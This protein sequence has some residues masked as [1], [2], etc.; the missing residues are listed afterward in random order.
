V[1]LVG[2]T[3]V[4]GQEM[5]R[6]LESRDFP[7]TKLR[8]L[9]SARSQG[10]V[11]TFAGEQLPVEPLDDGAFKGVDL[12]LFSAGADLARIHAPRAVA[13]GAVV[14]DNSS[15]FRMD[16]DVPLVVPE[17]NPETIATH[18]GILANPNC[19]TILL[20]VVLAPLER[21]VGLRR[22]VVSTYQA[23]SGA[24]RGA[25]KDLLDGSR[26]A[27]DGKRHQPGTL[28]HTLAFNVFAQV[29]R[30][31]EGGYTGEED[32]MLHETRRILGRADLLLEATCVRVAVERCHSEAVTV[33][34]NRPLDPAA[35]RE[36]LASAPGVEIQDD[37]DSGLSP[38]P[39]TT[40]GQDRV[41][42]GRLRRSRVFHQGLSLWLVGD[43]LRKGAA[44]NAVQI[45]E[46][47]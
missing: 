33:E 6:V 8:C 13:Q 3:G 31:L 34:L 47:L 32:K 1:A 10:R 21:A 23:A 30:F 2:A 25:M 40:A 19:S 18:K 27:L 9:A 36:I 24:G 45:A 42:V 14:V 4:V 15:A 22:V 29:D 44:L 17:V 20:V 16:P 7:V 46:K 41:A 38:Q 11:V 43:Q 12:V 35:A 39:L 26:A 37:P 28:P 5:L